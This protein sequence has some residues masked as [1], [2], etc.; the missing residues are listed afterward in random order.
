MVMAPKPETAFVDTFGVPEYFTT[1]VQLESAGNG[2][3]RSIRFVRR[4]ATLIPV[5]S[6]VTPAISMMRNGPQHREFAQGVLIVEMA[7]AGNH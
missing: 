2:L 3:V 7:A 1:D 6:Y 5:F 4:G